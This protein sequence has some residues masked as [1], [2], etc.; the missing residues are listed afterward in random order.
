MKQGAGKN[1]RL[2]HKSLGDDR[3]LWRSVMLPDE[4]SWRGIL[5]HLFECSLCKV[6]PSLILRGD[7]GLFCF[8]SFGDPAMDFLPFRHSLFFRKCITTFCNSRS[9]ELGWGWTT[10]RSRGDH[11]TQDWS[12]YFIPPG[13]IHWSGMGMWPRFDQSEHFSPLATLIGS[14]MGT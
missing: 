14:G 7:E 12:K 3:M 4:P 5:N 10:F 2:N 1:G 13:L 11:M 8:A 9:T 6:K